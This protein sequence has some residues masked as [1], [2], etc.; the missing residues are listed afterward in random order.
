MSIIRKDFI[1]SSYDDGEKWVLEIQEQNFIITHSTKQLIDILS[2]NSDLD[3]AYKAFNLEF[4]EEFTK[5][6][7]YYFINQVLEK[8]QLLNKGRITWPEKKSFIRFQ[9]PLLSSKVSGIMADYLV[10]LFTPKFFWVYFFCLLTLAFYIILTIKIA[11]NNTS[12]LLLLL[13]YIPT[14]F[15]HELGH[16]AA[17]KRFAGRNG[18][19]GMGIYFIF[20]VL[21]S[22]ISALWHCNK[23]Q[24]II[25]NL[26]GIFMQLLCVLFFYGASLLFHK[27]LLMEISYVV[28]LYSIIQLIPFIRSDGYWLL[29]DI[30]SIPNLHIRSRKEFGHWIRHPLRGWRKKTK[31]D[32]FILIYGIFNYAIFGYFILS[33]LIFNWKEIIF[34]PKKLLIIFDKLLFQDFSLSLLSDFSITI[35][36]FYILCINY[37]HIL[38]KKMWH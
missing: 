21:Y 2:A 19:I 36:I 29:S 22:N 28:A 14:M 24:R 11:V 8:M 3:E 35:F 31:K 25:G 13:L 17:C 33:Q 6:D 37:I 34:F 26:A 32:V 9:I 7:F 10:V 1:L 4:K 18:E 15:L 5:E 27:T 16:A 12:L 23:E 20:P 38:L 30:F